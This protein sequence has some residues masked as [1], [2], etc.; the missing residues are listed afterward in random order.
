M[1]RLGIVAATIISVVMSATSAFAQDLNKGVDAYKAGDY[2]TALQ[3]FR[4]LA[5]QGDAKIQTLVGAMYAEGKGVPQDYAEAFKWYRLAAEQGGASAQT[6][7]GFMYGT[8]E[9]VLQDNVLAHMWANLGAANGNENGVKGRDIIA[10]E[11]TPQAIKQAQ[12]MAREC[13][14]NNYKNCGY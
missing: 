5:E 14:S 11:M 12:A 1:K 3:E 8:G 13:M 7:L 2:A 6:N 10:K 9:G 4:P